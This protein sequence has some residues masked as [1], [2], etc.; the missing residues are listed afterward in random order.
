[1]RLLA[2]LFFVL[3][4]PG[5]GFAA[6]S[7]SPSPGPVAEAAKKLAK[8][9]Q[10]RFLIADLIGQELT[11]RDGKTVGTVQNFAVAPGGRILAAV[12]TRPD[13]T[14]IAV[15]FSAV[16][17]AGTLAKPRIEAV[18]SAA[19]LKGMAELEALAGSLTK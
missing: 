8:Q 19:E 10:D 18:L 9:A 15:P 16:K 14:R 5:L 2:T 3:L 1:M 13:G 17:L 4:S 7:Q 11:G 6:G 12:V